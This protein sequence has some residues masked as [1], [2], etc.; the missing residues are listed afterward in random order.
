MSM[1]VAIA[2]LVVS[3]GVLVTAG[4]KF[5][6]IVDELA[7]RTGLGEALA[8]ALLLGAATS[9]PGLMTTITGAWSGEAGFAVSNAIGGI[10]AQTTFLVMADLAYRRVNLEHAAASLPNIVQ[11]MVL[12]ALIGVVLAATGTPEVVLGWIHPATLILIAV[13]AY[14]LVVTRRA[15][16]DP[17]WRPRRTAQTVPDVEQP[18]EHSDR[19]LSQLWI[20][21]AGFAVLVGAVGY[22][23]GRAGVIIPTETGLSGSLVGAL[24]TSVITS[25]PELVTVIAA[26]RLGAL[27]LAVSNIVGGNTFDVLFVAAGDMA[28]R[29][30][31]VY[32]A[33]DSKAVFFMALTVLLTSLLAAGMLSREKRHI[34]FEGVAILLF[35]ALGVTTLFVA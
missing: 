16:T 3:A 19:P 24:F 33:A 13:Y 1:T 15:R 7:D 23:I 29:R 18:E 20:I 35:Y 4:V 17:M 2:V 22:F 12:M 21:F 10:A 34:G 32:H 26:V 14:G 28:F 9:L 6:Q 27:T 11:T 31:S 25:F 5:T 8:G 30:G